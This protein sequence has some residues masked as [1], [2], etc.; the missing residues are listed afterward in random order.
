MVGEETMVLCKS[1]TPVIESVAGKH[2]R[3]R[4]EAS[5]GMLIYTLLVTAAS[6]I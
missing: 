5:N 4:D 2:G 6:W 1:T 3:R